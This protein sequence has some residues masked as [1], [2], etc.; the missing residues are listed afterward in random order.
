MSQHHLLL[1]LTN[2]VDGREDEYNDWYTHR[3]LPD[4]LTIPGVI[5]AQR[6]ALSGKQRMRA[7]YPW[8]YLAIYE[9]ETDDLDIVIKALHERSGGRTMPLTSA[10]HEERVSWFFQPVTERME[11][12]ATV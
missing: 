3:H 11:V 12:N 10:L 5:A 4:V 2:P 1:V 6:F 8:R 9:I 7:P